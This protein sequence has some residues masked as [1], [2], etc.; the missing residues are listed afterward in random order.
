V[1]DKYRMK[2]ILYRHNKLVKVVK[3]GMN[4]DIYE[5]VNELM[6]KYKPDRIEVIM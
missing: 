4:E 3:V 1:S 2:I 6:E 5:V